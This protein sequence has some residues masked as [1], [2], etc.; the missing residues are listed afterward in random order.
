MNGIINYEKRDDLLNDAEDTAP[1]YDFFRG[2]PKVIFEKTLKFIDIFENSKTYVSDQE[3]L[4]V[5]EQI[6][7][8]I[9]QQ[10]G[11]SQ[12]ICN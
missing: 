7:E 6:K 11:R 12:N 4:A 8:Y 10:Y 9:N 5:A 2:D 3:I 1:V